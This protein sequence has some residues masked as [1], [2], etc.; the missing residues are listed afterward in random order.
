MYAYTFFIIKVNNAVQ[1]KTFKKFYVFVNYIKLEISCNSDLMK[2]KRIFCQKESILKN[3]LYSKS[4]NIH[5]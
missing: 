2:K 5:K 4:N 1:R 3:L